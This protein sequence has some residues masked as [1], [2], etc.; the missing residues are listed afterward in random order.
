MRKSLIIF[1]RITCALGIL[2]IVLGVVPVPA[3]SVISEVAASS[4]DQAEG[5][6]LALPQFSSV[7]V[8]DELSTAKAE[9]VIMSLPHFTTISLVDAL[10]QE[11]GEPPAGDGGGDTGGGGG[12]TGGEGGDTG[13]EGGDTGG[14]GGDTGGEGG[15]TG[16]EGGDIGG[17]GGDTGGEGGDTGDECVGEECIPV[18]GETFGGCG[19]SPWGE[20]SVTCG[21][22]TQTRTLWWGNPGQCKDLTQTCTMPPCCA[23]RVECSTACGQAAQDLPDGLCGTHHCDATA[24]CCVPEN[25]HCDANEECCGGL[26][27]TGNKCKVPAPA[28]KTEGMPCGG[29]NTCCGDLEC[30]QKPG[31]ENE[32][33]WPPM[34]PVDCQYHY[35]D[36]T[37]GA[38]GCWRYL[39]VDQ[40]PQNGGA[41]CPTAWFIPCGD[42]V[43]CEGSWSECSGPC[44][45]TGTITYTITTPAENGGAACAYPDGA[46]QSC[47][48]D[49][50]AP[51]EECPTYCDYPGGT[52]P[53]GQGGQKTCAATAACPVDC[54]LGDFGP[55]SATC[56]GGTQ[57]QIIEV[58]AQNGGSCNPITQACNTDPCPIDCEGD[59]GECEGECGTTGT[60]TFHVTQAAMYGGAECG[61]EDGATQTCDTDPCPE[62]CYGEWGDCVGEC[63]TT[64][65]MTFTVLQV[66]TNGGEECEY[67]DGATQTCEMDPCPIDCEWSEWSECSSDCGPGTQTREILVEAQYGGLECEGLAEQECDSGDCPAQMVLDPHC[68]TGHLGNARLAWSFSNPSGMSVPVSW[69]LDGQTGSATIGPHATIN[70]GQTTDGPATHTLTVY[71]P[72]GHGSQS[73]S[74]DCDGGIV[75]TT[76]GGGGGG[77]IPVTGGAGGPTEELLIIPVTGVDLSSEFA[78]FQ[79]LF[80]YM[81]LMMFGV[82]LFLEGMTK[83]YKF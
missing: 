74:Y 50:C 34:T 4:I 45:T 33:C 20:C 64:G 18:T 62:D 44:G 39:V 15:D 75:T 76:T 16:G 41:A 23:A 43:D 78:G 48:N 8:V 79:K 7:N 11:G 61:Y 51:E 2:F 80:L 82:T 6:S 59:W 30:Y 72:G 47:Q 28:C 32:K 37:C 81:G 60:Q 10:S 53:D 14:E 12:D 13:G 17:E 42:P 71:W 54:V 69:S 19:Y 83:K 65:E 21:T 66:A 63:G 46:T 29:S 27:C 3:V 5:A 25:G 26:T 56:G 24:A 9:S 70:V 22:G 58:P 40:Y 67:E 38:W 77:I 68:V 35:G 52:V 49:A 31:Q 57:T 73:S 55:C 1:K 36:C